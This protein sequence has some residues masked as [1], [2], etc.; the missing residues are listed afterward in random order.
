VHLNDCTS[1]LTGH[2]VKLVLTLARRHFGVALTRNTDEM[3]DLQDPLATPLRPA[4]H[5]LVQLHHIG[6][7][8]GSWLV[9]TNRLNQLRKAAP[10]LAQQ[11]VDCVVL[12]SLPPP[13]SG[14]WP[15][16]VLSQQLFQLYGTAHPNLRVLEVCLQQQQLDD[17]SSGD[18]AL[19]WLL[20]LLFR[21]S[22]FQHSLVVPNVRRYLEH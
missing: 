10:W 6:N 7:G 22:L 11:Q 2:H 12:S 4:K 9:S 19:A 15:D 16:L 13:V 17:V 1:K 8:E 20:L 14:S 5:D 21:R 18:Y 3:G